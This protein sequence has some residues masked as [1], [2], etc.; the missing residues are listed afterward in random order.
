MN[1]FARIGFNYGSYY[2][3]YILKWQLLGS[4]R[5]NNYSTIRLQASIYV[6]AN[7]INWSNGSASIY[8]SSFG[9]ATQYNK[10]ETVVYT[11]D[12]NVY[13]DVNGNASIYVEGSINTTFLMNGSCGGTINIPKIDR[14]PPTVSVANTEITEAD[15]TFSYSVNSAVDSIQARLN[16]GSWFSV[17][18][19]PFKVSNLLEDT[20]YTI[21]LR[22]KR[23]INQVWGYSSTLSFRT[24]TGTF[25]M[26]S[27]KGLPFKDAEVYL[28]TESMIQKIS[29]DQYINIVG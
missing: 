8:G 21:Q 3:A 6:G 12:V 5:I 2:Y 14:T 28:V 26:I 16:G 11:K 9:L 18:S 27:E 13:H 22:A 23:T 17:S 20:N 25:A 24:I 1:E 7:Y 29:K 10:G 19:N 4:D 15:A